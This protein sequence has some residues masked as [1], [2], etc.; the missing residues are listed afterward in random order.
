MPQLCHAIRVPDKLTMPHEAR[1][2]LVDRLNTPL[3]RLWPLPPCGRGLAEGWRLRRRSPRESSPARPAWHSPRPRSPGWTG[4]PQRTSLPP[5]HWWPLPPCGRGLAE[6]WPLRQR[7]PRES[8]PARPA[9]HS[10]RPRSPGWTGQPQRTSLPPPHW[11]LLP[12]GGRGLA[13]GWPLRQRSPRES[14]PARPAWH[15]PR[16]RSPGWTGQPQRT[17][18]PPPHWWPLP[19][20][21]RGLAEGWP[22]RQRSPRESSPARPAWHSPRPRSPGWT[23]QP[24]QKQLLR[25]ALLLVPVD[26]EDRRR[27]WGDRATLARN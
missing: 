19:P 24:Q 22:L 25:R 16:P 5:P 6:G 7:S 8:S 18:L 21:G 23:G 20:C 26:Q 4:Q 27:V 9:W 14:S 10:P 3:P 13:E 2:A 17:S 1:G 11:W 15:S 12:A